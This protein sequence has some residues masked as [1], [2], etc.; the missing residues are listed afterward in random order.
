MAILPVDLLEAEERDFGHAPLLRSVL[1]DVICGLVVI[2]HGMAVVDDLEVQAAQVHP[3][4]AGKRSF[5]W[6]GLRYEGN[7]HEAVTFLQEE[8]LSTNC[9]SVAV[10]ERSCFRKTKQR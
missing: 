3:V 6:C 5:R 10:E 7:E 2:G 1:R 4:I 8:G 9:W